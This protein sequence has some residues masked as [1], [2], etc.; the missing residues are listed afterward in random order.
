MFKFNSDNIIIG[1]LKQVL[2]DFNL[3]KY[4][5]YTKEQENYYNNYSKTLK[6]FIEKE[7]IKLN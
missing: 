4:R 7:L 2:Y 3:P 6:E 1:Y 5:V